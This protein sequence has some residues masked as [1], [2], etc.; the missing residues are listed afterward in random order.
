M[1][2]YKTS[3]MNNWFTVKV[4]YVKQLDN[5]ALKR[6]TE[7]YL[8]AAMSFTDA[9]KRIYE[10]LEQIIRGEFNVVGIS[11]TEIH[12]IFGYADSDVWYKCKIKFQ[13]MDVE[14]EKAR[15][16]TQVILLSADSVKQAAER[17][18]ESLS[19]LMVDFE[20]PSIVVSPIVEIFPYKEE[21]DKE[22]S[23]TPINEVEQN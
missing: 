20:I 11:R 18:Q 8:L 23:R 14:T 2:T 7:P 5:G 15:K 4:K 22:L 17:L 10:E 12:D 1:K 9:E 6:V 21:L 3:I 19:G 16:V 13:S